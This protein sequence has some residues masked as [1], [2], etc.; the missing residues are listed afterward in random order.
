M[1]AD[2]IKDFFIYHVEKM[3]LVV[4]VGVAGFMIY[5]GLQKSDIRNEKQPQ[6]LAT[7]ANTVRQS[8]DDDHHKQ[9]IEGRVTDFDVSE[10]LKKITNPVPIP[11]YDDLVPLVPTSTANN[12]VRRKDP[13]LAPALA[14]RVM[15]VMAAVAYRSEDGEYMVKGLE[16]AGEVEKVEKKEM[17]KRPKKKRRS[18]GAMD[19]YGEMGEESYGES[20]MMDMMGS[21]GQMDMASDMGMAKRPTRLFDQQYDFGVRPEGTKNLKTATEQPPVPGPGWFIAGT[22]V[23]PYKEIYE[24]YSMALSTADG[25]APGTRDTPMFRGFQLQRADVTTKS[26]DELD[27]NDWVQRDGN[28]ETSIDAV[29]YWS[30]FAPELVSSEYRVDR[31]LTMWIPPVLLEDYSTFALHPLIP[32]KTPKEIL[33]VE[34]AEAEANRDRTIEVDDIVF[35]EDSGPS[36]MQ[37]GYGGDE[38]Y[39][40]EEMSMDGGYGGGGYGGASNA[41]LEV[42]PVEHKLIRFYD[43][44]YD[45]RP[46]ANAPKPGRKYVYRIRYSVNDPNFPMNPALQPKGRT[47]SPAVY[48]RQ[49]KLAEAAKKNNKRDYLR[50]SDWSTPSDPVQLKGLDKFYTGPATAAPP[51]IVN[52]G[53]KPVS[54]EPEPPKAKVLFSHF[55]PKLGAEM[56]VLMEVTEGSVL[57][58]K[59]K[60]IDIVDPI[61]LEVKEYSFKKPDAEEAEMGEKLDDKFFEDISVTSSATVIDI[62]GGVPMTIQEGEDM[63]EPS[64]MLIFDEAGGL[65]VHDE[66]GD[67]EFYRIKSFA[68]EREQ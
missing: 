23:I 44:A 34:L 27:E 16:S 5:L 7:E 21:M 54:F 6:A 47:L 51:K 61:S 66:A 40:M 28:N 45:K 41:G 46:D 62:D 15:P 68:D 58:T 48:A 10:E 8:V 65:H 4:V 33:A 14:L 57:A 42:N 2:K 22:A 25:Y 3:I 20:E 59:V 39:G 49:R 32:M 52:V 43:F 36:A 12:G 18:R 50:W 19:E 1:D 11:G 67:Q 17:V 31:Y 55:N 26:V 53:G 35:D 29:L 13:S 37:G 9:V 64:L 24:S 56:P 63:L 60:R 30:G 38:E